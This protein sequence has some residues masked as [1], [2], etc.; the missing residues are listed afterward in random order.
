MQR[1]GQHGGMSRRSFIARG[2]ALGAGGLAL[3]SGCST[4]KATREVVLYSSVDEPILRPIVAVFEQQSGISVRVVGDT[5]ATKS[6]GLIERLIAEGRSPRADVWWSGEQLGVIELARRGLLEP[7]EPKA[8]REFAGG[9]PTAMREPS[10][11]W[12][13]FALRARVIAYS[14]K[15]VAEAPTTLGALRHERFNGRVG[16]AH[17]A[18]GTTRVHLAA[19]VAERGEAPTREWFD[20][21]RAN[22][23]KVYPGN[24]AVVRAISQGEIDVGLTDTDDVHA[25]KANGWAVEMVYEEA[26]PPDAF[27]SGGA[28]V[29]PNT[30]ARIKSGPN[31]ASA[32]TLIEFILSENVERLLAASDSKNMPI[33][34]SVREA[35][36]ALTIARPWEVE[37]EKIAAALPAAAA[38]SREILGPS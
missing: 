17:P 20:A 28:L 37:A 10:G 36:P 23:L 31:P 27:G 24:S 2:A 3:L 26:S 14:T 18:F 11:L 7:I 34:E 9:W 25:G 13:G 12:Y 32:A 16:I 19:L 33:H 1:R 4:R 21:L 6:T 38:M 30:V 22:G 35:F 8:V 15:R 29:L 5:E